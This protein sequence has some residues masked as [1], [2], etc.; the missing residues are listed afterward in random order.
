MSDLAL[1]NSFW[2]FSLRV[3][4]VPEVRDECLALQEAL[5]I[6]VN[7]LL[8]AAWLAAERGIRITGE[9]AAAMRSFAEGWHAT[10]VLPLRSV[11][12]SV[13]ESDLFSRPQVGDFRRKVLAV[14]LAAEKIEQ[15]LLF[16]WAA[17]RWPADH[18]GNAGFLNGNI[19][20]YLSGFGKG[21]ATIAQVPALERASRSKR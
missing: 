8:F 5:G 19:A 20:A 11:R 1:D 12:R 4:A 13:K 14:E 16:E 7:L 21:A 6:D 18:A 3:Y 10:A 17:R 15:G 2:N 9:D